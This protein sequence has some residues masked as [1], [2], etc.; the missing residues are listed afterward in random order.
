[1]AACTASMSFAPIVSGTMDLSE[2][3]EGLVLRLMAQIHP[4]TQIWMYLSNALLLRSGKIW[5]KLLLWLV[6]AEGP[7]AREV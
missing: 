5:R 2:T 3:G 1:M 4:R 6:R 7:A